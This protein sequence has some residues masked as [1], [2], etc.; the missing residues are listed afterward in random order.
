MV[1][2]LKIKMCSFTQ[3]A[4]SST[5]HFHMSVHCSHLM[6]QRWLKF[7]QKP[8]ETLCD[9]HWHF[10]GGGSRT[11]NG[12]STVCYTQTHTSLETFKFALCETEQR[13]KD[14]SPNYVATGPLVCNPVT[15]QTCSFWVQTELEQIEPT[16]TEQNKYRCLV[17]V[18]MQIS[19]QRSKW[20]HGQIYRLLAYICISW[21]WGVC[22]F[23]IVT[24]Y[25]MSFFLHS[26]VVEKSVV[27]NNLSYCVHDNFT[28]PQ[29]S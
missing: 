24:I 6:M 7:N 1:N 29:H 16:L 20:E 13:D 26:S 17:D 9:N 23:L 8:A 28:T 4:V 19:F 14:C 2:Y 27:D 22:H 18:H 5:N 25:S 15:G 12:P 11:L 10:W 21:D 3:S